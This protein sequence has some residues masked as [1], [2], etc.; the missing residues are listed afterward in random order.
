MKIKTKNN[1][2]NQHT[3][4][5]P[6]IVRI[7]GIKTTLGLSSLPETITIHRGT[8]IGIKMIETTIGT[9]STIKVSKGRGRIAE[10]GGETIDMATTDGVIK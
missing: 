5:H 9:I 2:M 1:T 6:A 8:T 3:V 4:H 10:R 7:L